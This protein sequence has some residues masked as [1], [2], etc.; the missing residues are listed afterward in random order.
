MMQFQFE[1]PGYFVFQIKR[2][3]KSGFDRDLGISERFL[4]GSLAGAFSQS[5]IYPMEVS[6]WG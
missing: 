1:T 3:M 6:I 4:A 5:A 2:S